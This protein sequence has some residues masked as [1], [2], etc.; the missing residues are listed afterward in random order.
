MVK[1]GKTEWNLSPL[2]KGDD[3]VKKREELKKAADKFIE[4]WKDRDDYLKKPEV[5]KE[6]LDEYEKFGNDYGVEG[7]EG[8]YYWLMS[9]VDSGDSKIKAGFNKVSEFS[10]KL[11]NEL[12]FFGMRVSKIPKKDQKKF[13]EFPG[14]KDYKH[15]LEG[16][17]K[18]AKYLLS[19]PEE[20]IMTLK[21]NSAHA[22]WVKMVSEFISK[23][24]GEVLDSSGKKGKKGFSEIASL[25][26]N[27]DKKI[28]DTAAKVFNEIL[29]KYSDV[30]ENEINAIF[31]NKKVN[32]E[33]RGLKRPD[34]S[35]HVSDDIDSEVVDT[36]VEAVSSRFDIASRHYALKAK[37][38]KVDKLEYHERNVPYGKID[39]KY[40]YQ[41]SVDLVHKVF[42]DLDPKFAEIFEGFVKNGQI[43][44][45]PKKGKRGGAFCVYFLKS[46]PTYIMLNH[47][48]LL[49]DVETLAHELGHG[50]N[51]ELMKEKQNSINFGTPL[52][53]AEVAS[54]FV[55]DFV[56]DELMREADDETRL[57]LMVTKLDSDISSIMRQ[58]ACYKFEQDLHKEFR[59][60]GHLSKDDI[61]KIFMKNMK[62]YMGDAVEQSPGSQN[63]WVYWSHIRSF[64]YVYS[65]SSGLLISKSLQ[66]SVKKDKKFIEKVKEFLSSGLS[67]S[68]K[69]I[70]KKTGIDITDKGFWNNGLDEVESLL[71]ETEKLAKK[72]GKI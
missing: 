12:Q 15:H 11:V 61:G 6:A 19:E 54:T 36:L 45:Y 60:K 50:I 16:S 14:L 72:L 49:K 7:D 24:E 21:S 41:E 59:E 28:R 35:R 18:N 33:L 71:G 58:I 31:A 2:T 29:E 26:S 65:Y 56:M 10:D 37:L 17:F 27:K 1:V 9:Q 43:D 42:L 39:K 51:D 22:M 40:S 23:E 3:F 67:A 70:F 38:M 47:T 62:D 63:W 5:L 20:K 44:V 4:K 69:D 8:F 55:E 34:E 66:A 30:A 25:L 53:T 57:A 48:D 32:D 52:S 64:F 13:L 68:P 46:Q